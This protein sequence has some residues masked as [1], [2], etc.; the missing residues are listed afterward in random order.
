[1]AT[2]KKSTK[3]T[4]KKVTKKATTAKTAPRKT[5]SSSG[6]TKIRSI[7]SGPTE[8][9]IRQRAFEVFLRRGAAPGTAD[10]DWHIAEQE[11]RAE[12]GR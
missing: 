6:V 9:Q 8:E 10:G 3:K 4:T 5:T 2:Q 11:L 7:A 12:M 1:M